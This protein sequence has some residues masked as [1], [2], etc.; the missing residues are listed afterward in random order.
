MADHEITKPKKFDVQAI[1]YRGQRVLRTALTTA[2]TTLP[3]IPQII[4][5]VQGQWP[6]ATGLTVIGVQ[7]LAINSAL[8]AIIALPRVNGWLTAIGFGSTPRAVAKEQ[9]AAKTQVLQ[10]PQFAPSTADLRDEQGT[11]AAGS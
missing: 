1:W 8:T 4:Q 11:P 6:A 9:A 2:L 10:P 3:L 7:A 5:I